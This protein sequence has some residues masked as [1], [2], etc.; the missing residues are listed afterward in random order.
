MAGASGV[1]AATSSEGLPGTVRLNDPEDPGEAANQFE[2]GD[3]DQCIDPGIGLRSL[4]T[5][6]EDAEL[7]EE[8]IE[9]RHT[10][11]RQCCDGKTDPDQRQSFA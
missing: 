1:A 9:R 8:T 2:D 7:A 6:S 11:H 5:A 4:E 10:R 3:D